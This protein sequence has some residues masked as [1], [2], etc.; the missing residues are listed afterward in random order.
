MDAREKSREAI[1]EAER[2]RERERERQRSRRATMSE[3]DHTNNAV[4]TDTGCVRH[5]SQVRHG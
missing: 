3:T 2:E 1:S 5:K 4:A